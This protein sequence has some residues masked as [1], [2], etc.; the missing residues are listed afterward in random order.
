MK[1][2]KRVSKTKEAIYNAMLS[3]LKDK[4]IDKI[5]VSDIANKAKISRKTFYSHYSGIHMLISDVIETYAKSIED[6]LM[7][8]DLIEAFYDKEKMKTILKFLLKR[9]EKIIELIF[10][11][12]GRDSLIYRLGVVLKTTIQKTL[13]EKYELQEDLLQSSVSYV[14]S[15]I[16]AVY[17]DCYLQN[18][19][20]KSFNEMIDNLSNLTIEGT[21]GIYKK[22]IGK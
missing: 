21:S 18:K 5:T 14:I 9:D 4:E 1:I 8:I 13:K 3:I 15:G 22:F 16:F 6:Y 12:K 17:R 11:A 7:S 10:M 19:S 2:D 20:Q